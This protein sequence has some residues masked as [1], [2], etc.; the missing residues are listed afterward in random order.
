MNLASIV[1]PHPDDAIA[2]IG[3]GRTTTYGTLREQVAAYRGGLAGLG[4]QPGDR[5]GIIAGTNWY[6]AA[7]YLAVIG[8]G[9]VAVPLN[10]LSPAR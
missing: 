9:Y 10:P 4:L 7:T 6:F 5:V 3:R 2:L 1:E 8:G